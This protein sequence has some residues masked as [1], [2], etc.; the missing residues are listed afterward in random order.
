MERSRAILLFTFLLTLISVLLGFFI[1]GLSTTGNKYSKLSN[2]SGGLLATD[3]VG[4]ALI[5]IYGE[6]HS[7]ESTNSSTGSET[8]LASLREIGEKPNIKGI[9]LEIDSP[10][11]TAAASQEIY[12]ELMHLRK[13]K[14]IV[15][16]MKDMAASGGYYIA[17]ASDS[18]LALNSTLTG[19]IGVVT[20]QPNIKGFLDKYGVEIRT[21]KS[22]KY[23]DILSLF[24]PN[25]A[26]EDTIVQKLLDDTYTQFIED[27]ARGRNKTVK[28]IEELAQ[29]RIYSGQE[30]FRNKLVD[31][32]GGRRE[33]ITKLS[34]L[35]QYDGEIPLFEEEVAPFEK[36][37][38]A[39]GGV[40]SNNPKLE[41]LHQFSR[42]KLSSPVLLIY[43]G[44]IRP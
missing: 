27:V 13:T 38:R 21:Y 16:S 39:L 24:R 23:K 8:I 5:R 32:I 43:P 33:A 34:E 26:E 1:I 31:D 12:N 35:C 20:I 11:G 36:M 2:G 42:S 44:G 10:G 37:L 7:G 14:K 22:G 30:A 17:S 41:F 28:S 40:I 25:T 29:G 18:I 3:E 9:L 4:A 19:S 6:I 15:T